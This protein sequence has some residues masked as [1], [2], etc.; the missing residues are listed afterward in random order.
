MGKRTAFLT[1]SAV[2]IALSACSEGDDNLAIAPGPNLDPTITLTA[3]S[4]TSIPVGTPLLFGLSAQINAPQG[5]RA[6]DPVLVS[7]TPPLGTPVPVAVLDADDIPG[8]SV[9]LTSC[10][11]DSL[12]VDAS[13][14]V[15]VNTTGSYTVSI[16]V[17]D[18][19]GGFD[20]S[21][22]TITATL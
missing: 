17:F 14:Q 1:L 16:S 8:C 22:S 3:L 11:I 5:I 4:P 2:M 21:S 12:T 15:S 19:Q 10:V 18:L 6:E 9:G 7:V 13:T 20:Q